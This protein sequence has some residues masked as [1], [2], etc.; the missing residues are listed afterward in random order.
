M[1]PTKIKSYEKDWRFT[2]PL[3]TAFILDFA[4]LFCILAGI[5][6]GTIGV[7]V[8]DFVVM[9]LASSLLGASNNSVGHELYHRR[10]RILKFLG[11]ISH[12]KFLCGHIPIY[13]NE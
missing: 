12:M 13:H 3:L 6:R 10:N 2:I 7:T 9:L 11:L 8:G 5:Y 4:G 1:A